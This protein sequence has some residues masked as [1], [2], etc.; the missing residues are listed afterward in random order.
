MK[1]KVLQAVLFIACGL[2]LLA[3]GC[4]S[5]RPPEDQVAWEMQQKE[6]P[7]HSQAN[8]LWRFLHDV[9][10]VGWSPSP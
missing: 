6:E 4:A 10:P 1:A 3:S 8:P 2:S 9:W 7:L 5:V